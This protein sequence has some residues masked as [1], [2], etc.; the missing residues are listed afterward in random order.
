[1]S[2]KLNKNKIMKITDKHFTKTNNK[3]EKLTEANILQILNN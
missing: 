2:L 1:M 3:E